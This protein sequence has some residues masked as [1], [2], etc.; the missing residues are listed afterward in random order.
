M[1]I[2]DWSSDVCSSDL[3]TQVRVFSGRSSTGVRGIRLEGDDSIIAM[4]ILRHVDIE[5]AEARAYMK[6]ANAAR[7]A[8]LGEGDETEADVVEAEDRKRVGGGKSV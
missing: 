7:R 6:Q 4:S 2:S 8:V 1:R 3:V 5:P